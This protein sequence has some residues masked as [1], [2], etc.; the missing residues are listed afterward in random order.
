MRSVPPLASDGLTTFWT[1]A[2]KAFA[3]PAALPPPLLLLLVV[4][5]PDPP[6]HAA[7]PRAATAARLIAADVRVLLIRFFPIS[8]TVSGGTG[9][10]APDRSAGPGVEGVA[11]AVAEEVEGQDGDEDGQA[12]RQHEPRV[13]LVP[14]RGRAE[15][16]APR[17]RRR[18]DAHPEEGQ[19]RLE[20]D[21]G[22]DQQRRV[23]EDRRD[24]VGQ[25]LPPQDVAAAGA[26]AAG[27]V[28][29]LT[30]AQR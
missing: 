27:R 20:E 18:L 3:P 24:Q 6:P 19:G 13:D 1:P 16:P 25:E 11:Q 5:P 29:E 7:S 21:V 12:G 15:H 14:A 8:L 28:H 30:L 2:L 23:D 9:G 26:E 4:E 22:R 17:R 10:A